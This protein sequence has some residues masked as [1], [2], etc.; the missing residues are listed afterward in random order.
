[1]KFFD[2]L[3]NKSNNENAVVKTLSPIEQVVKK[4]SKAFEEMLRYVDIREVG[5]RSYK[6]RFLYLSSGK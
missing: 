3:F 4:V 6:S 2:F 1:M 5:G